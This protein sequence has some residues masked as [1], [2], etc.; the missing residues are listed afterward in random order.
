MAEHS[1]IRS[2]P[3][4][5]VIL[6][7]YMLLMAFIG[8]VFHT[9]HLAKGGSRNH[10]LIIRRIL[11]A[12][13]WSRF[14]LH[15]FGVRIRQVGKR[16]GHGATGCMVV[17]NHQGYL[18]PIALMAAMPCTFVTSVD[19]GEQAIIGS[20]IRGSGCLTVERRN[21]RNA[22]ND[23]AMI[24]SVL[25]RGCPIALYPEGTSSDGSNILPF[26]SAMLEAAVVAKVPLQPV[27]MRFTSVNRQ[28]LTAGGRDRIC[29][30]G[31]MTFFDHIFRFL[32]LSRIGITF[33]YLPRIPAMEDRRTLSNTAEST[34]RGH[35]QPIL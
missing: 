22:G 13:M 2:A 30:Y 11:A 3:A 19:M 21:R 1:R 35:F 32:C 23:M 20:I 31:D 4:L 5:W 6:K 33:T 29:W 12:S 18:D 15:I 14:G 9:R 8:F 24:T 27:L 7:C 16:A 26:K 25:H 28:A 17:G 10:R 34:I